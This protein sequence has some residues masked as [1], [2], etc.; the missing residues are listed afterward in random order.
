MKIISALLLFFILGCSNDGSHNDVVGRESSSEAYEMVEDNHAAFKKNPVKEQKI[1]K[2]ARLV[3]ETQNIEATHK[4][5]LQL[6]SQYKGLL[7]SDDSGKDYSRIYKNL[8]VRIP[9]E[10]FEPFLNSISEGV[11]YFDQRNI[12]Q[13]DVSEEFIDLE[14]RLKAKR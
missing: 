4:N 3:F 10:N 6:A 2:T 1:I 9:T 11:A 14:A 7:Q 5:I 13:Q 12:S 8:V